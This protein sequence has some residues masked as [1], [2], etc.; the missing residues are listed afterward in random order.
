M[1]SPIAIATDGYLDQRDLLGIA[2]RGYLWTQLGIELPHPEIRT[3]V[4]GW[5]EEP[6][7][8]AGFQDDKR[9]GASLYQPVTTAYQE[10]ILVS[11][12]WVDKGFVIADFEEDKKV[13]V[14]TVEVGFVFLESD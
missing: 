4:P 12:V 9:V 7:V 10:N 3:S 6:A 13:T 8:F 11:A 2:S 5:A 14:E 1:I